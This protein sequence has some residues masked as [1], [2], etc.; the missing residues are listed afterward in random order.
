LTPPPG[1]AT[2]IGMTTASELRQ[3][4]RERHR[5]TRREI[6]EAALTLAADAPFKDLTV[7]QISRLAGVSRTAFYIHY[8]DKGELLMEAV[9]EVAAAL[10]EQADRWWHGEGEPAELVREAVGGVAR[11]WASQAQ[12][13]AAVTEASTYDDEVRE[14]WVGV[15]GRFVSATEEHIR[16]EVAAGRT[17]ASVDAASAADA[18]CWM[19]ERYC[20]IHLCGG[21]RTPNQVTAELT[22]VWTATLYPGAG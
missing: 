19:T 13:L 4:R 15:V 2:I 3:G 8:R 10:Y 9:E 5:Q 14:F 12:V 17:P 18:L 1:G 21:D 7:D 20:Y 6:I 22:R 16:A 11:V